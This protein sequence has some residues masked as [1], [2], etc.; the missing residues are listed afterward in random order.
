MNLDVGVARLWRRIKEEA[1]TDEEACLY[2]KLFVQHCLFEDCKEKL[3]ERRQSDP[4]PKRPSS[5]IGL[6]S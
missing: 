3:C 2:L 6:T 1:K 5:L 4:S